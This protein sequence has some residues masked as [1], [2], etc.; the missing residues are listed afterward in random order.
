MTDKEYFYQ[1]YNAWYKETSILSNGIYDNEHFDN[2]V[3]MREKA[4]PFLLEILND[5]PNQVVYACDLIYPNEVTYEG[6]TPL[7]WCC[8]VWKIILTAKLNGQTIDEIIG[9]EISE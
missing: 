2:I 3:K 1:E 5:G 6:Y 9:N 4:A 8:N 7:D